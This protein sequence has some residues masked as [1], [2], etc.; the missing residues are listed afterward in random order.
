M[1]LTLDH[2]DYHLPPERIAK[3]PAEPRDSSRL[4]VINRTTGEIKDDHFYNL[5]NYLNTS[6]VIVRNNTKVI[7]ARIIGKKDAGGK[8]ELLLTKKL[9]HTSQK[10]TWECL[11]KPGLK[12]GQ[13]AQFSD[14]LTATCTGFSEDNYTRTIEFNMA[15]PEFIEELTRIGITPLPPYIAEAHTDENVF[16]D[17]YQTTYAKFDGSAAAPTAG[18]HFTKELDRKLLEKGINI[19][20]VTLHV[21]L[22]TFLPVKTEHVT[23][24]HMHSEWFEL[25]AES[26][27]VIEVAKNAG[28][29][30]IAVGTTSNRV[31]ETCT[32]VETNGRVTVTPQIADTDIYIY[33]PYKF[34]CTDALITNFHLPKSTLLMLVSAFVSKPNSS[35]QFTNFSE[36]LIGRAYKHAIQNE[37]RF[38]SFGDGMIIL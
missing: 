22:G 11:S 18:L 23:E 4:L 28:N 13:H 5:G 10:E 16:R 36:S 17:Q 26:A 38:Y 34:V 21:G 19:A 35:T 6:D 1:P 15:G 14:Q 3:Y 25:S 32:I 9:A 30:I 2:F 7:P 31:L 20:E 29:R 33:P 24:H 12:V 27:Q 37:Y 8:L